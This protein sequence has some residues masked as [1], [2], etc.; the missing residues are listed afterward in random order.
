MCPIRIRTNPLFPAV[1][2]LISTNNSTNI[3]FDGGW[4]TKLMEVIANKLKLTK[5]YIY[6]HQYNSK[7]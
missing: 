6:S 4:E 7:I 2:H 3:T 5:Y 1:G